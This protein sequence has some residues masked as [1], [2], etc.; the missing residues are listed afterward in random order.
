MKARH[1]YIPITL[2][3]HFCLLAYY[4]FDCSLHF[5]INKHL[6]LL[7][8]T[9]QSSFPSFSP[10]HCPLQPRFCTPVSFLCSSCV[11]GLCFQSLSFS[12]HI[13]TSQPTVPTRIH[14]SCWNSYE[15]QP[16]HRAT[17]CPA[18]SRHL[19]CFRHSHRSMS[20]SSRDC[21][22]VPLPSSEGCG[23]PEHAQ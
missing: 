2:P 1:F 9:Q 22:P 18:P 15:T 12:C 6:V 20:P 16:Q 17:S 14:P 11:L 7:P 4:F 5:T 8:P 13:F 10:S 23:P 3:S 21:H 19:F